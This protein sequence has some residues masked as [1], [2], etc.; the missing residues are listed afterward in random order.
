MVVTSRGKSTHAAP[1]P[2]IPEDLARAIESGHIS[3][4]QLRQLITLEAKAIG[5][6]Y[7]EAI[8]RARSGSLPRN[9][10]GA[11]LDLLVTM[12]PA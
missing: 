12:L 3:Q 11:D 6:T 9:S 8:A 4:A 5:L 7:E 10:T 1:K 2:D